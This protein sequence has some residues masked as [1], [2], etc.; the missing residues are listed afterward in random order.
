M[1]GDCVMSWLVHATA[2]RACLQD[3]INNYFVLLSGFQAC[4]WVC[5]LWVGNTSWMCG[6]ALI[7]E[8]CFDH[9]TD[10]ILYR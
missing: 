3:N 8:V 6:G 9:I 1:C 2:C 5:F 10:D 7:T 4:I